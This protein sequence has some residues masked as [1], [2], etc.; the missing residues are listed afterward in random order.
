[1][2][3][4]QER[5]KSIEEEHAAERKRL[6][7]RVRQTEKSLQQAQTRESRLSQQVAHVTE[8]LSQAEGKASA[9]EDELRAAQQSMGDDRETI[10]VRKVAVCLPSFPAALVLSSPHIA[11][12][13]LF[14]RSS[15]YDRGCNVGCAKMRSHTSE[16]LRR[17]GNSGKS[18]RESWSRS[19]TMCTR[20]CRRPRQACM[21]CRPP[22]SGNWGRWSVGSWMPCAGKCRKRSSI[23]RG[24]RWTSAGDTMDARGGGEPQCDG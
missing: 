6:E 19:W 11:V 9:A 10:E 22:T 3:L 13:W 16:S 7:D 4:C 8:R 2:A 5:A 20:A 1:M 15:L 24:A 23:R 21:T 18:E 17:R 14:G 12:L